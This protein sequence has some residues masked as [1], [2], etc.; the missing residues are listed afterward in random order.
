MT[1]ILIAAIS[2]VLAGVCSMPGRAAA[3]DARI[4]TA[5]NRSSALILRSLAVY[6]EFHTCFSC[7]HHGVG[8]F[9]LPILRKRG[10]AV[11]ASDIAAVTRHTEADLRTDI[12]LYRKMQGQP[13]AVP[14]AGYALL[15]LASGGVKR[16]EVTDTVVNYILKHDADRGFWPAASNRP[17]SEVSPFTN[18][19]LAIRA[20]KAYGEPMDKQAIEAR[21]AGARQWLERAAPKETEDRVFRVWAMEE[22]GG[23]RD[24]IRAEVKALV[25]E[26]RPDGGWAQLPGGSSDAYATGSALTMLLSTRS[27]STK[28]AACRQAV[29]Y[30]LDTQE[31]DGSWHVATRSRPSMPYFESGFPHGRD[32]FIS[33]AASAWATAALSLAGPAQVSR[34]L[35]SR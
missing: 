22:A 18:A 7:H 19:F 16:D 24:A 26:Q 30:L 28:D 21:I 35:A 5:V 10:Y 25:S 8:G 1:K 29:K 9:M 32:Q 4:V 2:G 12:E 14:R 33:I 6:P 27:L 3:D 11:T 23:P 34:T 13:G 31:S 20:L 17:P 15:A